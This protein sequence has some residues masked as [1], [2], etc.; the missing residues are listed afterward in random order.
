LKQNSLEER[1]LKDGRGL[2]SRRNRRTSN[3]KEMELWSKTKGR[4]SKR[5]KM[6]QRK[7]VKR[8]S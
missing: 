7:T 5:S 8:K 1:Q 3:H 6:K 4:R 2:G